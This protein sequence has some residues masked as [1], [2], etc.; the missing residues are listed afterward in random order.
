VSDDPSRVEF[1]NTRWEQGRTAFHQAEPTAFLVKYAERLAGRRRVLVPLCGK[2]HD[3]AWLAQ[4]GH[5]V[6]GVESSPVAVKSFFAERGVEA[7]VAPIAGG[8]RWEAGGVAIHCG[9]FFEVDCGPPADAA[10]D[11]AALVALPPP[12]QE[13]YVDRVLSLL[14]PGAPIL[15]VTF[16]YEQREMSGPP[17]AVHPAD[18]E[19]LFAG[20]ARVEHLERVELGDEAA[21]LR[22]RGVSSFWETA[23]VITRS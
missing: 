14:V 13:R 23:W 17:F 11:R 8:E 16:E 6:V 4:H 3:L 15:L 20:R 12:T 2:S 22:A 9:D 10:F 1:W 5:D 19:R 7:A 18:V 21:H